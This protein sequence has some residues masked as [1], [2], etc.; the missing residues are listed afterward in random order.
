[1]SYNLVKI[2]WM[3]FLGQKETKDF[4]NFTGLLSLSN[5]I[6]YLFPYFFIDILKLSQNALFIIQII[7][8]F[9]CSFLIILIFCFL[10]CNKKYSDLVNKFF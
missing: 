2:F 1:M 10:Y 5:I 9:I 4:L 6:Y 7:S 3:N 8:G